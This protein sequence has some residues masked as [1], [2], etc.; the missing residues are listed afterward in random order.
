MQ[1][2]FSKRT[3][4]VFK[5][6]REALSPEENKGASL[7]Y[8]KVRMFPCLNY[9]NIPLTRPLSESLANIVFITSPTILNW[10]GDSPYLSPLLVLKVLLSSPLAKT[11]IDPHATRPLS[12]SLANIVVSTSPAGLNRGGWKR[13]SLSQAF[14]SFK[15]VTLLSIGQNTNRSSFY[16]LPNPPYPSF[17]K[18]S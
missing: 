12:E 9:S 7:A 10:G 3:R 5:F 17:S 8:C 2:T 11:L 14:T 6:L 18:A 16:N 4:I 1:E 13:V 15:R